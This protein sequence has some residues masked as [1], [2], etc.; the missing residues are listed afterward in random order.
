[1]GEVHDGV[2]VFLGGPGPKVHRAKT[3]SG[4]SKAGTAEI[5]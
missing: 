2:R 5:R 1:V 3:K 4:D